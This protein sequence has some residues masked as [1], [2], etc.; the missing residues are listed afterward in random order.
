MLVTEREAAAMYARACR[1][2][3]GAKAEVVVQAKIRKLRAR[4]DRKGVKAWLDVA[5]ALRQFPA[6]ETVEMPPPKRRQNWLGETG[7]G[8]RA[9]SSDRSTMIEVFSQRFPGLSKRELGR[10]FDKYRLSARIDIEWD[11]RTSQYKITWIDGIREH[12]CLGQSEGAASFHH[13]P[14]SKDA[15]ACGGSEKVDLELGRENP[16]VSRHESKR[17]ISR[18]AIGDGAH[19]SAVDEPVLLRDCWMGT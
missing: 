9:D 8:T 6:R 18:R 17:C 11:A 5:S 2:W 16:G 1:S 4:K 19:S 3:Y 14:T 7:S 13:A 10:L 12:L 15:L